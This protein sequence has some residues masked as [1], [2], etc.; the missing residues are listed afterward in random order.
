MI[1]QKESELTNHEIFTTFSTL[2]ISYNIHFVTYSFSKKQ[3]IQFI[4]IAI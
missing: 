1:L 2:A 4:P 3:V